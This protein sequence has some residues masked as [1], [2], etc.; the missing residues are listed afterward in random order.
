[1]S[2]ER[3][4]VRDEE[5]SRRRFL[6]TGAA[7]LG[8]AACAGLSALGQTAGAAK[9]RVLHIV[10]HS[11]IDA[12][13]LWPWRDG[14]NLV[15][16]TMRSA[17]ERMKE[18]A[19]FR[20]SHSSASHYRWAERSDPK[21]FAE[22]KERV[23][24]GR[25]ELVGGWPVEPDCNIPS[26]ESLVR[27]CLYGKRYMQ[28]ALGVE[29]QIGFNPDSFGHPAGLPSIL[30]RA[31][32]RYY[33]FMRPQEHEMKLPLLFWWE[34][35]DG[36]RVLTLRI[37]RGYSMSANRIP[38]AA[39]NNFPTGFDHAAFFLGVGDHGGAVTKAQIAKV[40]ELQQDASLPELR[41]STMSEFFA[42]V[43]QS[44]AM[45]NLPVVR[46]EL[47]YHSRG[48]YSA[49]GEGKQLNRRAERWLGHAE[50]ISTVANLS[51][52]HIYPA[53]EYAS[54]W[55]KVLFNQFHDLLAGTAMY[56]AYRD[57]RDSL[58]WACETAQTLRVEAL[59]SMARRVDL[60]TVKE[61]A[62][63]AFNPL[64]WPRKALLEYHTE[65]NPGLNP[66]IPAPAGIP[67]ITH[68]ESREGEKFALQFRPSDSMTQ[69]WPRLSAWVDLPACGYRVFEL[70]HGTAPETPA[71]SKFF[72]V[73]D[74]G[75]GLSSLKSADGKELLAG[76]IG[77][78][79]IS[80]PGD[81]WGHGIMKYRQ[82]IGRPQ[83]IASQQIEDGPV[84]R[85]TRQRAKWNN[86]EIVVDIAQL[87]AIDVIE[88]RFVIDWHERE[89]ILKFE[90]PTV[91]AGPR[92]FVKVAGATIERQPNG[93]E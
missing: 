30:R 76:P 92:V 8:G 60:S 37:R 59:E 29:V 36:N 90:I 1:M 66:W 89:Q 77:L 49:Y 38:D 72:T 7:A 19:D 20:Y 73:N 57:S 42:A 24:E 93:D 63:F 85:V 54:A 26:T 86:S 34:G 62:V 55:W 61:G 12:A 58:G 79:V 40:A 17:L 46:S 51:S 78:V 45:A 43:E 69:I 13:W 91:I 4:S 31:G 28:R 22:I 5:F 47:Q 71:Y 75:F 10:G 14:S 6:L 27:Q 21:M 81:T 80:D 56:T 74:Q 50:T 67:P 44:P 83:L 53:Q 16:T 15:L 25:W 64:P 23:R 32:Y 39:Q 41:W 68:L 70:I 9:R 33:V 18:T 48:C 84:T 52:R 88:F 65:R 11:H 3:E 87:K 35:P 2:E 82:E